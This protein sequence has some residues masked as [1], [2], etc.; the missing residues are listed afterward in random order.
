MATHLEAPRTGRLILGY[1][2]LYLVWGAN[3]FFIK[4]AVA[5]IPVEWVLALRFC[6]AGLVFLAAR[7]GSLL[8]GGLSWKQVGSSAL[9]S[10]LILVIGNGLLTLSQRHISSY[11]ASLL[12]T[13]LPVF[14]ATWDRLLFRIRIPAVSVAGIALGVGGA[15]LLLYDGRDFLGSVFARGNVLVAVGVVGSSLGTAIG[16]RLPLPEDAFVNAGLQMLFCGLLALLV[17]L[18]RTPDVAAAAAGVT[19]QSV[20]GLAY[21]TVLGGGAYAVFNWL[22]PREPSVRLATYAFVNPVIAVAIGIGLAG[23]AA[24][25]YIVPAVALTLAGVLCIVYAGPLLEKLRARGRR[26]RARSPR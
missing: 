2:T 17:A 19:P 16:K 6:A 5:T 25:P 23:E 13:L 20:I 11:T 24:T 7:R 22:V 21:I 26:A 1:L 8:R 15:V 12:F 3:P 4:R 10:L 18:L 14:V 9:L